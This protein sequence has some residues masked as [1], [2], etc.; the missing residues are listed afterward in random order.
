VSFVEAVPR[1]WL[2]LAASATALLAEIA[3][4]FAA[5]ARLVRQH[6]AQY[7]ASTGD[8]G[9][10]ATL[11]P[12][13]RL[14]EI[15]ATAIPFVLAV[16]FARTIHGARGLIEQTVARSVDPTEKAALAG[17]AIASDLNATL[18]GLLVLT[19][20]AA[21]SCLAAGLTVSARRRS[22]GLRWAAGL[23]AGWPQSAGAWLRFPGPDPAAIVGAIGT[24]LLLGFGP[25]AQAG[26][27]ALVMKMRALTE[28]ASIDGFAEKGAILN[29]ALDRASATM[30]VGLGVACI[31][32]GIAVIVAGILLWNLSPVRARARLLGETVRVAPPTGPIGILIAGGAVI[33]AIAAFVVIRPMR[34]ENSVDWPLYLSGDRPAIQIRTPDVNGPDRFEKGPLVH[35]TPESMGLD[36][37][38]L[39]AP[40]LASRLR[41]RPATFSLLRGNQTVNGPVL[42]V[43]KA[44]TPARRLAVALRAAVEGE[45]PHVT[46]GFLSERVTDRPLF[47]RLRRYVTSAAKTTVVQLETDAEDG[48][49]IVEIDRFKTCDALS[50]T[51]IAE[52]W[53]GHEVALLLPAGR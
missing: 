51:I 10:L 16:P 30:D 4:V 32:L 28:A 13:S 9:T 45:V 34:D 33:A 50:R 3:I 18:M 31:G 35:I 21:V 24:F 7:L 47:G 1:F 14:L 53:A 5:R 6:R 38:E 43:C 44:D 22:H 12:P 49:T 11:T 42:L 25:I 37:T 36:G 17:R 8:W 26:H 39:D 29:H 23:A 46:F 2:L 20:V 41:S 19:V 40:T 15:A 48:A 27:K 52:R